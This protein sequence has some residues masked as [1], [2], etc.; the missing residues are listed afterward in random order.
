MV[1]LDGIPASF[2]SGMVG[3]VDDAMGGIVAYC[4]REYA[5]A[6][7]AAMSAAHDRLEF[8]RVAIEREDVSYGELA[9]LQGLAEFITPG[10][11]VLLE[12]AGV[13]EFDDEEDGK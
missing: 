5:P 12:W 3:I 7:V 8:I 11:V 6:I 1:P 10:D 9:E 2:T 4:H 13:P